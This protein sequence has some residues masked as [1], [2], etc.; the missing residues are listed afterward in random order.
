MRRDFSET[1][2]QSLKDLIDQIDVK[3]WEK[4]T[5]PISDFFLLGLNIQN[6]LDDVD[7]Y[8][9]KILDKEDTD[10]DTISN[11]FKAVR[12][13]DTAYQ[14]IFETCCDHVKEQREYIE[15]LAACIDTGVSFISSESMEKQMSSVSE[16]LSRSKILF[17]MDK[18]R[19]SEGNGE[20]D[21]EYLREIMNADPNELPEE[22]YVALVYVFNE[23]TL[24][25]KETFIECAYIRTE[26]K[27]P[28]LDD[29]SNGMMVK[30]KYEVSAG[31]SVLS[32]LYRQR[33]KKQSHDPFDDETKK[34]IG[35]YTLLCAVCEQ[36]SSIYVDGIENVDLTLKKGKDDTD[37]FLTFNGSSTPYDE[38]GNINSP[39]PFEKL[40]NIN[41]PKHTINVYGIK[42]RM[43]IN[44]IFKNTSVELSESLRVNIRKEID[45]TVLNAFVDKLVPQKA[46]GIV[47]IINN[48]REIYDIKINGQITNST[49]DSFQTL[50][51]KSNTY[52]ALYINAS[53]SM[54]DGECNLYYTGIDS[55]G[56]GNSLETY[57]N[58]KNE[59]LRPMAS[60]HMEELHRSLEIQN[61][62]KNTK[63][64][65][66]KSMALKHMEELHR[67]LEIQNVNK[68]DLEFGVLDVLL[69]VQ[70]EGK[71]ELL[72]LEDYID[73]YSS[74]NSENEINTN[75]NVQSNG[76]RKDGLPEFG[77]YIDWYVDYSQ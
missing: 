41:S 31:L 5:D 39:T 64:E 1:A 72:G 49:I 46:S 42:D 47:G 23:M 7:T 33:L 12:A 45:E 16:G 70:E 20:Y 74:G 60:K 4:W 62:N 19:N 65:D 77:D 48:L 75:Q 14:S 24:K 50:L 17:Y 8:H 34:W 76:Q 43:A 35:N 2:E 63:D 13:V 44:S 36:G 40:R 26:E 28:D 53:F 56:L 51:S 55:K 38:W 52:M 58:I 69:K 32:E 22:L 57:K 27:Y 25:E 54:S 9:K 29:I 59:K 11:I 73:W 21:Y 6:Y 18:F 67:S 68:N 37:Y 10:K 71:D 15:Q 61:A 30:Y 3:P 66:L